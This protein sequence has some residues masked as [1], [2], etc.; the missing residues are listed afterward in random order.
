[1][2]GAADYEHAF[3]LL[4]TFDKIE[5]TVCVVVTTAV[6]MDVIPNRTSSN[7]Q[8]KTQFLCPKQN[9]FLLNRLNHYTNS[10]NL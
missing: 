9:K 6:V 5:Q 7:S 10:S 2:L 3:H 4:T 8:P 1:M